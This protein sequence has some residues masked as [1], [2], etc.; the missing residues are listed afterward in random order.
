MRP[1]YKQN[2]MRLLIFISFFIFSC[3]PA[4]D[5]ALDATQEVDARIDELYGES[6]ISGFSIL[7]VKDDKIV[8]EKNNGFANIQSQKKYTSESVQN[9]ASVSKTMIA[10]SIMKAV[11]QGKVDLDADI[12][13]YLPF[14]VRN[15]NYPDVAIT[16]RQLATHTSSIMDSDDYMRSYYFINGKTL[17][18][19]DLTEEY[20]EYFEMVQQNEL[21]DE[22]E[23]LKNV[24]TVDGKWYSEDVYADEAPGEVGEYSNVAAT[25][26]A[27]VVENAVGMT[28][29]EYTQSYIFNPLGMHNTGWDI[30][31]YTKENF[32]TRYFSKE[33]AV[34]DYYLITKA[35]GGLYTSTK[36]F[37]KFM[38]EMVRGFKGKG[39][40]LS[41]ESFNTMFT[42]QIT[43]D[44]EA[45]G[46]FWEL[47]P[48]DRSFT[49]SGGD[50]GVTT[51]AAYAA[52]KDRSM[53]IFTNIDANDKTYPQIVEI[54]NVVKSQSW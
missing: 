35:D 36:D 50:P 40:I 54:W 3:K 29:E 34:P 47:D 13:E 8:Y 41:P 53:I 11:D 9:I 17:S 12:N 5:Q 30:E 26:A 31:T 46:I 6:D 22:S 27:Y 39:K 2:Q 45:I 32:A 33:K 49:H 21:I 28:Y 7:V 15:P 4:S 14:E 43:E 18:S 48:S 20:E 44:D 24:L 1:Y 38:I 19:D 25:L 51:N 42:P 23:F 52:N 37:S 16:L 10:V